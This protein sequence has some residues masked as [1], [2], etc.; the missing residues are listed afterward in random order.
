MAKRESD[1]TTDAVGLD[2]KHG[3]LKP[4][5]PN[6]NM[7]RRKN[8]LSLRMVALMSLMF[9]ARGVAIDKSPAKGLLLLTL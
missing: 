3:N 7:T 5:T 6:K 2:I 8:G 1:E 9:S 4:D